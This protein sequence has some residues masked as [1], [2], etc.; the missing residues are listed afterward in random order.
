M[1]VTAVEYDLADLL[2]QVGARVHGNR[3][4]CPCCR[5]RR[6]ISRTDKVY[7]CH[8]CGAKGNS[9]TLARELGLAPRLSRAEA[10]A[11]RLERERAEAVANAFLARV[12][13]A[14][15]GLTALHIVLLNLRDEARERLEANHDDETA[16]EILACVCSE[17]PRV[18]ADLVVL[19][20]GTVGD[21]L[22]W[23]K[24]NEEIRRDMADRVLRVGGV[25]TFDG[26][27]AEVG[28]LAPS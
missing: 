17:L 6:T 10:Q 25:P 4:D 16:W 27:W 21:R 11:M 24:A 8:R 3:A 1:S 7:F 26:K 12:R 22:T 18:R 20:E 15:F 28:E 14:R 19:S 23:F 5:G 2:R 13:A 9:F